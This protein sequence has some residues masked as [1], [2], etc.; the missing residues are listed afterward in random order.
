MKNLYIF[1]ILSLFI[2][3]PGVIL[4]Q[5]KDLKNDPS[6]SNFE[7]NAK[8]PAPFSVLF[9]EEAG[10]SQADAL[11]LFSKYLAAKPGELKLK[12]HEVTN[13]ITV[14]RYQQYFKGIKV[15]H[16]SYVAVGKTG[17]VS[18]ITGEFFTID[19]ATSIVPAITED[20]ARIKARIHLDGMVPANDEK[21]SGELVFVENGMQQKALDGKVHLAYK[22]EMGS[23]TKTLNMQHIYVDAA[24]GEILFQNMLVMKGCFKDEKHDKKDPGLNEIKA[25]LLTKKIYTGSINNST[26]VVAPLAATI[27][28]GNVTNMVTRFV[29]GTHRLEALISPEL[30]PTH[31]KNILHA[32][33]STYTLN[34]QFTAAMAAS[35]EITDLDNSWTAAEYNNANHDNTALDVQWGAQRVYDYWKARHT[36]NSWNNANGILNCYVHADNNWDNAFWLGGTGFNCMFYGDGSYVAGGFSTLS[37]LD[38]TGHEIGHGV[39]QAT[40]NL[41]YANQSGAMNEGFSDIWGAAIERFGDPY[42]VDAVAK[43]YFDIGEEITI[44]G[45]ALRSMS[46]PKLY[47]QPD[48]YLGTNWYSGA[49]DNGGVH[50]NSG[51]LNYWFYLLVTGKAIGTNDIGSTY[52][53]PAIGWVDA[54]RIA[55]LGETSLASNG[56][57]A[58]CRTAMINAATTLFGACS[59]QT[60]AVTRAWYAVGVGADFVPC[61]PHV[62]FNGAISQTVTETGSTGATCLKTKTITVPLKITSGATQ[63]ATVSFTLG[64]TAANAA[65]ADYTISPATVVFPPMST[66]VQNLTITINNDAYVEGAETITLHI[67]NVSTTGNAI[68][69]N[70]FQDYIVTITDDDYGPSQHTLQ[71]NQTLYSEDFTVGAGFTIA[72]SGGVVNSWKLGTNAGTSPHFGAANNCAY[73]SQ[74]T[75]TFTYSITSP[76]AS[77]LQTPVINASNSTN[78]QLT[79][80]YICNGELAGGVYYDYGTL[81]YSTNGGSVWTRINATNYQGVSA[82]TTI[83]VPLPAGA[84]NAA[85]LM[86]G[87]RW[88]NDNTDG[89]QPPFGIDNIFLRGDRRI[90]ASVQTAVNNGTSSDQQYLG[91]NATV[92]FYDNVSGNVMGTIQNLSSFDYGC[93]TFEVDRAGT[94]AL[95]VTGDVSG[96][97]KQRLSSKTFRVTP[98]AN[99]S[100]GNY[101]VNLYYTAAEKTGYETA[102]TRLWVA[103][104]GGNNGVQITKSTGAINS[105]T[106]SSA[107][108]RIAIES[109][110]TY[111]S[112]F[113]ITASFTNGFSGFAAGIPPLSALPI[114]LVDFNAVRSGSTVLVRWKVDQQTDVKNYE[115]E[116]SVNGTNFTT[117]G[118]EAANNAASAQYGFTHFHPV[119]GTNY[120][121]LKIINKNGS[122][123]YSGIARVDIDVKEN[124]LLVTPNPV[125]GRFTV[126][127]SANNSIHQIVILDA[128]GKKVHE[129]APANS[130]GTLFVDAGGFASGLYFVRMTDS[131]NKV[132]VQKF[133]KR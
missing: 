30:Y 121:R 64:G 81:W 27:Y 89:S 84:E 34:S 69:G 120:Y 1:T 112:D 16:G 59:L 95:F 50:T 25:P 15:E 5:Q 41:T 42:E 2:F 115:V 96:N 23:H 124:N 32:P 75:T 36:R 70:V 100:T 19:P 38:V 119:T 62:M 52:S 20:A 111:G 65:N 7:M 93:T 102:S 73:V 94:S 10:Y 78:L 82:K 97:N 8:T 71:A 110:G 11:Q 40:S 91:P 46:N 26:Q 9:K 92:N 57:Y 122:Y 113:T 90:A 83:T 35:L 53:V 22:F 13:D 18:Y 118:T 106:A 109:V 128:Q 98:A 85:S 125:S 55:F 127:Y 51:V 76:G 132:T 80:D 105:L 87:F 37:S 17:K 79:Y 126:Q 123:S 48:T 104:N 131:R 60:E 101:R 88:D 54:E 6:I 29:S 66:A 99:S 108:A 129:Y 3:F 67:Q 28:S 24:T 72:N 31:V 14:D 21:P 107:N 39:C 61:F 58:T 117:S 33:V 47:G 44:G 68:I 63:A 12:T 74:N 103:D 114:T 49:G 77:R 133:I 130:I 116:H 4:A 43:S 86:L 56:T 45:G